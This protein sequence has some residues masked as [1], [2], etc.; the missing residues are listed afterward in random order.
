MYVKSN[1]SRLLD[2]VQKIE[3]LT[4]EALAAK[5]RADVAESS[6]SALKKEGAKK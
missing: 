4:E 1:R 5:K 6:A 3:A 2:A